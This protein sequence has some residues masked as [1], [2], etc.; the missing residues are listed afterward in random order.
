MGGS[1]G[2]KA[3]P[4]SPASVVCCMCGDQGMPQELFRCKTCLIRSQHNDLY[5]KTETYKTCNW[6]IREEASKSNNMNTNSDQNSPVLSSN[7][8]NGG[9]GSGNNGGGGGGLAPAPATA[10]A[11]AAA[12]VVKLQRGAFP[13][14]LNKPVKKQRLP[15]KSPD[16]LSPTTGKPSRHVNLRAK[17][18][19]YKLLEE[20]SS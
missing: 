7:S 16:D 9:G 1:K 4:S 20:V 8:S 6:C 11:T 12:T 2:E 10:T 19:R 5:P 15:E 17:V 3:R 14:H 13:S 18:R